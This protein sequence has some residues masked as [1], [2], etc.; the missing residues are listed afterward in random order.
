MWQDNQTAKH[1][2]LAICNIQSNFA[3]FTNLNKNRECNLFLTMAQTLC[4]RPCGPE[5]ERAFHFKDREM[6]TKQDLAGTPKWNINTNSKPNSITNL[7]HKH[8]KSGGQEQN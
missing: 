4:V 2:I 5:K 8:A 6:E 3:R 1:I 7:K